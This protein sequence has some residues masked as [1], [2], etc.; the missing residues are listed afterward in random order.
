MKVVVADAS[1]INYLIIIDSIEVLRRL[2]GR[3]VIP[4][5]VLNELTSEGP[6]PKVKTWIGTRPDW[7]EVESAPEG[8]T[9]DA[10]LDAGE[11]AAIRLALAQ[12]DC[13]L[14][15]DEAKGRSVAFKFRIPNTGTLG[16]LLAAACAGYVDL[17]LA[18]GNLRQTNFRVSQSLLAQIL[19]AHAD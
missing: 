9:I 16:V 14:L 11:S 5:E 3:V 13:L 8:A 12:P 15:I 18:L 17:R 10:V 1:P 2:Y 4:P 6:P 19:A 7:I